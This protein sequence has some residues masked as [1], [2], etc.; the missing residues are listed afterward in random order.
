MAQPKI[1]LT[2][3][4]ARL[5]LAPALA[6]ELLR[7]QTRMRDEARLSGNSCAAYQRDVAQFLTFLTLHLARPPALGDL[8]DLRLRDL[9][10]FMAARRNVRTTSRSLLRQLSGLRHLARFL[11][12]REWPV[13]DVFELINAPKQ[14]HSLP[15]PVA[16]DD[17]RA[18]IQLALQNSGQSSKKSWVGQRD[19]ALLT[20]LYGA[21]LRIS[22]ALALNCGDIPSHHEGGLRVLGKGGKMRD[23]P[24][25]PLVHH[26]LH[27][28]MTSRPYATTAD[29]PVFVGMRGGRF[30]P[31]LAQRMLAGY[32]RQLGLADT[33][34]PHALRHSFA[35]HLLAAGSDLRTL[36]ELLG[37]AQLSSTQIYTEVD[38]ARL[39]AVYDKA[40]PRAKQA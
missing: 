24:L 23:V 2:G 22:E 35:T 17:A 5:E 36:Q 39:R 28:V 20:L 11:R 9:R 3:A 29:A 26:A 7:W 6:A 1:Q 12:R 13:S 38:T 31:R 8:A 10:A 18:L 40:H 14:T 4:L 21:G 30:S 32:R 27:E 16:Q 25:L 34:T 37:H 33:V 15:R 19:G